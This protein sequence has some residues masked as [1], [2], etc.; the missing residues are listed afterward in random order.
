MYRSG[1]AAG[2]RSTQSTAERPML[3]MPDSSGHSITGRESLE[4][5][6]TPPAVNSSALLYY[7]LLTLTFDPFLAPALTW[8]SPELAVVQP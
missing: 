5:P 7:K 4:Q 3:G 2:K 6:N 1:E 8:P